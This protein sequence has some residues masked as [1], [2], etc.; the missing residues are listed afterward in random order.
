[1]LCIWYVVILLWLSRRNKLIVHILERINIY[2][3]LTLIIIVKS[4]HWYSEWRSVK[5]ILVML[6]RK[7]FQKRICHWMLFRRSMNIHS[8]H[9]GMQTLLSIKI[10]VY[11][12]RVEL[13]STQCLISLI[14]EWVI[15]RSTNTVKTHIRHP[16][17]A[18]FLVFNLTLD[19]QFILFI[20]LVGAISLLNFITSV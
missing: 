5:C 12:I 17:I 9:F 16:N 8:A 6:A 1:M 18:H 20:K 10:I 4:I 2:I 13:I 19:R 15:Y 3:L 11:E 7:V 14:R